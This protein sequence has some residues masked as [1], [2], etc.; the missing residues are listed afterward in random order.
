ME[1]IK[2]LKEGNGYTVAT[3][4]DIKEFSGK[5][6]LKDATDAT[7][8]EISITVLQAGEEVP[9]FHAHKANEETYIILS[10]EGDYQLD[11]DVVPIKS[12]SIIRVAPKVMRSMRNT[13]KE[14]MLYITVQAKENS[15][16]EYAMTDG[17]MGEYPKRW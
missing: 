16:G 2:K 13:S 11:D 17:V 1:D 6:F 10:G 14:D 7:A 15:L 9:I 8:T 5:Q 3:V 12:G 4:G